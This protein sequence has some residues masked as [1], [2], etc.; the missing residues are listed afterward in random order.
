[1]GHAAVEVWFEL[2]KKFGVKK[3]SCWEEAIVEKSF[4]R[5]IAFMMST[6]ILSAISDIRRAGQQ[7]SGLEVCIFMG[8]YYGA[9]S[10]AVTYNGVSSD[11]SQELKLNQK[12]I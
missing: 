6:N 8:C 4:E 7:R 2:G 9:V 5:P 10:F 12:L 11:V 3:I 1:M